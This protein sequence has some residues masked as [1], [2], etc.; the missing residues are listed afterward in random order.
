[1]RTV[2]CSGSYAFLMDIQKYL[3]ERIGLSIGSIQNLTREFML[4][5]SIADSIK[6]YKLMYQD[7]SYNPLCLK[8]KRDKFE[9]FKK[10]RP[11]QFGTLRLN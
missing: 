10:V 3:Y 7:I 9:F 8:Y 2:F 5:Y 6:L 11:V 1:M 4:C